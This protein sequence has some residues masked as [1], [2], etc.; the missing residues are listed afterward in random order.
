[1]RGRKA[2]AVAV[3]LVL[4]LPLLMPVVNAQPSTGNWIVSGTEVVKN[5]SITLNGNLTV[6]SGGNLTMVGSSLTVDSTSLGEHYIDVMPGGSM[7]VYQSEINSSSPEAPYGFVVSGDGFILENSRVYDAGWCDLNSAGQ[8][9]CGNNPSYDPGM[10][11]RGGLVITTNGAKV[12]NTTISGSSIGLVLEGNNDYIESNVFSGNPEAD[13]LLAGSSGDSIYNNT[14]SQTTPFY[15]W[16]IYLGRSSNNTFEN[17]TFASTLVTV[18]GTAY[19]GSGFTLQNSENNLFLGN[20]MTVA[21]PF[22]VEASDNN[23]ILGNHIQA[24]ADAALHIV[25]SSYTRVMNNSIFLESNDIYGQNGGGGAPAGIVL[26]SSANSTVTG[27]LV[28]GASGAFAADLFLGHS[29]GT[30]IED[31]RLLTMTNSPGIYIYS[32]ERDVIK[33]NTIANCWQGL[34]LYYQSNNNTVTD[35]LV[36]ANT[37]A[38]NYYSPPKSA[39]VIGDSSGNSIYLNDFYDGGLSYDN[40]QN[41]WSFNGAGNY[42][43]FDHSGQAV[44]VAPTGLD[45]HPLTAP[46]ILNLTKAEPLLEP[47]VAS[48]AGSALEMTVVGAATIANQE[49][50]YSSASINVEAGGS[51]TISGS[52]LSFGGGTINVEPGGRVSV[53]N[54]TISGLLGMGDYSLGGDVLISGS[55]ILCGETQP[56]GFGSGAN[57]TIVHSSVL[58]IGPFGFVFNSGVSEG[59]TLLNI[60]DSRIVGGSPPGELSAGT[61]G[62]YE[63]ILYIYNSTLADNVIDASFSGAN[64]TVVDSILEGGYAPPTISASTIKFNGNTVDESGLSLS[65]DRV[66]FRGNRVT[67]DWGTFTAITAGAASVENNIIN[68]QRGFIALA[69]T[70]SNSVIAYN[71]VSNTLSSAN[72]GAGL[73]VTGNYDQVYGNTASTLDVSGQYN[74]VLG[75]TILNA[76][77]TTTTSTVS[78]THTSS[79]TS[80]TTWTSSS[81]TVTQVS[82]ASSTSSSTPTSTFTTSASSSQGSGIPEF[83]MQMIAAS[84]FTALVT[85]AYLLARRRVSRA[86]SATSSSAE[87]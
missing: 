10:Y 29:P 78:V 79:A 2:V 7:H 82:S 36:Y 57:I 9:N 81:E 58:S 74:S 19:L 76:V 8:P 28:T 41:S 22:E 26:L 15:D 71:Y 4:S 3:L 45:P 21:D 24:Y 23:T 70:A 51:L 31:N 54:S 14:F 12:T 30:T 33:A 68:F 87:G 18:A 40:G 53:V 65:G 37:T 38:S 6:E 62:G 84:A 1:M 20:R 80:T 17:N 86:S 25:Q 77:T 43:A 72:G 32:S 73:D 34:W 5:E 69:V 16:E 11:A 35:N 27:N 50:T 47:E 44:G 56:F 55:K 39:V 61:I 49:A 64:V 59:P 46:V 66:T 13:M 67:S 48:P 83:P 60:T 63:G 85:S 75:N 42:W 52:A